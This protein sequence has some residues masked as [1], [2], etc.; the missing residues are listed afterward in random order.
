MWLQD[1]KSIL[2]SAMRRGRRSIY[3][4][5]LDTGEF[6]LAIDAQ[7]R[8]A[9]IAR[10]GTTLY[11]WI[12]QSIR[13][14]DLAT[15]RDRLIFSAPQRPTSAPKLA[16]SPDGKTLA[17][18]YLLDAATQPGRAG[19]NSLIDVDGTGLRELQVGTPI[20]ELGWTPDGR[21]ILFHDFPPGS[22]NKLMRVP[23]E[24][25]DPEFTG[26]ELGGGFSLSPDG[27]RIAFTHRTDT[28]TRRVVETWALDNLLVRS[29][30]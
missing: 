17:F 16:L 30:R 21:A 15:G 9:A 29:A 11:A 12:D 27:T 6:T 23:V 2:V 5:N 28:S 22:V 20:G 7:A 8:S 18:A 10:D 25:G 19:M 1:G 14:F 4:L 13:A 24:G 3:R 26:L